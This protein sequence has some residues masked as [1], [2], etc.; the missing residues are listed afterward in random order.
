MYITESKLIIKYIID[1]FGYFAKVNYVDAY[2][3][4]MY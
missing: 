1:V 4:L 3:S 2:F